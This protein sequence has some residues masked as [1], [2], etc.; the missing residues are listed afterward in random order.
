M[1]RNLLGLAEAI[2]AP[3]SIT[4]ARGWLLPALSLVLFT[5]PCQ[6]AERQ[7]LHDHVPA[8]V[9]NATPVGRSSRWA[10]LDL[11]IGLPLREREA[12]TNLLQQ[13]Y[14]PASTNYHHYLTPEQFAQRFGP[15]E[16]DYQAVLA[17]AKSNGLTITGTH[18]NRTLLD[19]NRSVGD[20][21][22]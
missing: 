1:K 15:T 12:L 13:L 8:I 3:L 5:V 18:P 19:V 14:D 17:F 22:K 21:E 9:T 20:I 6:A 7:F 16:T 2:L 4:T 11:G 10:R